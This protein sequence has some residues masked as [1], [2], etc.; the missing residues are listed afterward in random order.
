ELT[1][2]GVVVIYLVLILL[3][4]IIF[5]ALSLAQEDVDVAEFDATALE[6][7]VC[8]MFELI[9]GDMGVHVAVVAGIGALVATVFGA[10]RASYSFIVVAIAAFIIR[11]LVSLWFV[12]PDC[13]KDHPTSPAPTESL[14]DAPKWDAS[15]APTFGNTL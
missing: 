7:G 2:K 5:P 8:D 3:F 15:F 13:G 1:K 12:V 10:Y 14:R 6:D 11:S 9:E 4:T